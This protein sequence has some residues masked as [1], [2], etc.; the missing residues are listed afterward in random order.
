MELIDTHTHLET[1]DKRGETEAVLARAAAEKV[2]R[3][4]TIGTVTMSTKAR[5]GNQKR[6]LASREPSAT[7]KK[8]VPVSTRNV[9][10]TP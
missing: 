1:F 6:R 5:F 4:V 10:A 8:I 3:L 2:T 7:T 9:A